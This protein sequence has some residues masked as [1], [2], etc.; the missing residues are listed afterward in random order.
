MK[1]KFLGTAAAEA[2]PAMFCDCEN[3]KKAAALGGKNIRTRSQALIDDNM[4]ID[5]P[6]DTYFHLVKNK[7]NLLDINYCLITHTHSD[8]FY[9]NEFSWL[10]TGYSHPPKEWKGITVYGSEDIKKPFEEYLTI[11][12]GFLRCEPRQPFV[13]FKA[14]DYKITP[15]KANHGTQNPYVYIIEKENKSL[16][17]AHDTGIFPAETWDYLDTLEIC[18]DLFSMDCNDGASEITYEGHMCLSRNTELRDMLRQH[19]LVNENTKFVLN[20]FSHNGNN[21]VYEEFKIIAEGYGFL[22][23]YD[24][25]EIE[26]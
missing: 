10:R 5:F 8:H 1:I 20:H 26:F 3:C 24:G 22:T 7:I 13:P 9:L 19:N 25:L 11:S 15:L 12:N 16:L 21:S 2:F 6:C 23:S 17:Y 14:G 18:F 4:L